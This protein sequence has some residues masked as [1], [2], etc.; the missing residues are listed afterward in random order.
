M[1]NNDEEGWLLKKW[2]VSK[3]TNQ[4]RQRALNRSVS[5]SCDSRETV[6][7]K[8]RPRR[9][10][11]FANDRD[12]Y[13]EIAKD[14]NAP[15]E[16]QLERQNIIRSIIEKRRFSHGR[17]QLVSYLHVKKLYRTYVGGRALNTEEKGDITE[18]LKDTYAT[19]SSSMRS[20]S[21]RSF[22]TQ[23]RE[24]DGPSELLHNKANSHTSE[25][26][27]EDDQLERADPNDKG[28]APVPPSNTRLQT[29]SKST[30]RRTQSM[31]S[32]SSPGTI[33]AEAQRKL[34]RFKLQQMK[35]GLRKQQVWFQC[36]IDV[37]LATANSCLCVMCV[38]QRIMNSSFASK[39]KKAIENYT[40]EVDKLRKCVL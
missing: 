20:N 18:I 33:Y 38:Q 6:V 26:D 1:A 28:Q 30:I 12:F 7:N 32:T 14:P 25:P 21:L 9:I 39:E 2:L 23:Q 22:R 17:E 5:T 34:L 29:L 13:K 19:L 8:G 11:T 37:F 31:P 27:A 4:A 40:S 15:S 36:A 10:Q 24:R 35:T 16:E 3:N